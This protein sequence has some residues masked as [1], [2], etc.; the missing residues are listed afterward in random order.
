MWQA[1]RV[2]G[3]FL[4]L[5]P[6]GDSKSASSAAPK[7]GWLPSESSPESVSGAM[8]SCSFAMAAFDSGLFS[9]GVLALLWQHSGQAVCLSRDAHNPLREPVSAINQQQSALI[10]HLPG[11]GALQRP[12]TPF[13]NKPRRLPAP[14]LPLSMGSFGTL[15]VRWLCSPLMRLCANPRGTVS[16][17]IGATARL[18]LVLM[19]SPA[20]ACPPTTPGR[21]A[22][23]RPCS[24]PHFACHRAPLWPV[25]RGASVMGGRWIIDLEQGDMIN[26]QLIIINKQST[27]HAE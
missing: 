16:W 22:F 12:P 24:S 18:M 26:N 20:A 13:A 7:I 8:R 5:F 9:H 17:R 6:A 23:A 10:R 4:R 15:Q 1:P 21:R 3:P 25:R 2:T 14:L 19:L 27:A 11:C